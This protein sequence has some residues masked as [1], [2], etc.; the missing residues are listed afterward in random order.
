M[1]NLAPGICPKA[2]LIDTYYGKIKDALR[3]AME[4]RN[5]G[6][7]VWVE[8]LIQHLLLDKSHAERPEFEGAKYVCSPPLRDRAEEHQA[9]TR[10]RNERNHRATVEGG[11]P[12]LPGPHQHH[13]SRDDGVEG[14]GR[15]RGGI[16][17]GHLSEEI[18]GIECFEQTL[19]RV[20]DTFCDFCFPLQDHIKTV[21]HRVLAAQDR[22][23]FVGMDGAIGDQL[24]DLIRAESEL[25]Q[26]LVGMRADFGA[27]SGDPPDKVAVALPGAKLPNGL[28]IKKGKIRGEKGRLLATT[29][30]ENQL[31][32]FDAAL[33]PISFTAR[34]AQV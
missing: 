24:C 27:G 22:S 11:E 25:G 2:S 32:A 13:V 3:E 12:V 34:T 28:E 21:L 20:I 1:W 7:R 4:A 31:L 29:V 33:L 6:V 18:A 15:P 8:A 16:V 23:R 5:R 19:L 17:Q 26:H 10:L 14:P 9:D 30:G